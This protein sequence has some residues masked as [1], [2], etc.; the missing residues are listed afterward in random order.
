VK[1]LVA[2]IGNIFLGDDGFGCAVAAALRGL[3]DVDVRDFGI[4]GYD[5]ALAL[6]T[7]LDAAILVDAC[8]R[9]DAPGTLYVIE[10]TLDDTPAQLDNHAIDPVEVLRLA[11]QLG[12]LPGVLWLVGC[13]PAQLEGELSEIVLAQIAPAAS[14]VRELVSRCT[15]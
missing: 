9:G 13:E 11:R 1:I 15:S 8:A 12:P 2:G 14:L 3:P 6:T 4:R 7:E 5:L 10:P